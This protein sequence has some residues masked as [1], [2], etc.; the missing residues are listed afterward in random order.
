ML[1]A[2]GMHVLGGPRLMCLLRQAKYFKMVALELLKMCAPMVDMESEHHVPF[3]FQKSG[4]TPEKLKLLCCPMGGTVV[5]ARLQPKAK[6]KR[7]A[8]GE[9]EEDEEEDQEQQQHQEAGKHGSTGR[10]AKAKAKARRQSGD[11]PAGKGKS[12]SKV[13]TAPPRRCS[14]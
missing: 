2:V 1:E 9:E 4:G 7:T 10:N 11:K 8:E 5:Y 6:R 13:G 12:P 14:R 3:L